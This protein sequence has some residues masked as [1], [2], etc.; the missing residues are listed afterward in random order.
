MKVFK[1]I[2]ARV[3]EILGEN[4]EVKLTERKK[5]NGVTKYGIEIGNAN[6]SINTIIYLD[7]FIGRLD[8]CHITEGDVYETALMIVGVFNDTKVRQNAEVLTKGFRSLTKE[9][10]LGKTIYKI[11]NAEKNRDV[12]ET[13]PHKKV[14]DLAAC[15]V[16]I[17]EKTEKGIA[18]M[19]ITEEFMK[20]FEITVEELDEAALK[21][22]RKVQDFKVKN[23]SEALFGMFGCETESPL[24]VGSGEFSSFGATILMYPECFAELAEKKEQ[25]LIIMPSSIHEVIICTNNDLSVNEA[26]ELVREVNLTQVDDED[27]LS[28]SVYIY[29]KETGKVEL[30]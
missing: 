5:N 3:K 21:N 6:E 18:S 19:T 7:S 13:V 22:T 27:V 28:D 17:F 15:Y 11:I 9:E 2:E 8:T 16:Y 30:G 26:K 1:E 10:I 12:L 14:F 25:D 23:M 4:Y 29:R 24:Y 20:H